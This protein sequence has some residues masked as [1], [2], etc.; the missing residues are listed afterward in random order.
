MLI[1]II[2]GGHVIR[3]LNKALFQTLHTIL[4]QQI[5]D[6]QLISVTHGRGNFTK[7]LAVVW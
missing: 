3:L 6:T 4:H 1:F 7:V 5:L 2:M